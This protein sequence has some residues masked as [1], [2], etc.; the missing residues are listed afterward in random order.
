M[1]STRREIVQLLAALGANAGVHAWPDAQ[2]PER[3]AVDDMRA[4]AALYGRELPPDRIETIRRA[5]QQA[6]DETARVRALDLDDA[7]APA[8]V[9][10]PTNVRGR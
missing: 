9:F 6:L 5:L 7:V 2:Q 8:V 1:E 3:I 4:A 10:R